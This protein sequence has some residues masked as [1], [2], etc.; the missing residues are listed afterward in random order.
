[1]LLGALA[2]VG[3]AIAG[4]STNAAED[5]AARDEG[6]L[7]H[8]EFQLVKDPSFTGNSV[9]VCG[10]RKEAADGKYPCTNNF[11]T[12]LDFDSYGAT[13]KVENLCP[14]ADVGAAGY[15]APPAGSLWDFSYVVYNGRCGQD[16]TK[17]PYAPAVPMTDPDPTDT[18]YKNDANFV[19]Y[20]KRTP[21]RYPN[22]SLAEELKPGKNH[23]DILCVTKNASKDFNFDVCVD[24]GTY[25]KPV[26]LDCGCTTN[27]DPLCRIEEKCLC[28]ENGKAIP[29]GFIADPYDSCHIVPAKLCGQ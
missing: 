12:C 5:V 3:L 24:E 18:S 23:N 7:G 1:M 25:D 29:Q 22:L 9:F 13:D 14:S 6:T 8:L 20:D 2:S 21:F 27:P 28:G 19:C 15:D 10:K 11:C 17:P 4:C 16:K 26:R